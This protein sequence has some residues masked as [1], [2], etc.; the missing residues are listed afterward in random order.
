VSLRDCSTETEL[1]LLSLH[2][3]AC[4]EGIE[5]TSA[6]GRSQIDGVYD[7]VGSIISNTKQ[8][9]ENAF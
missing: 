6:Y 8:A 5:K 2:E 4:R 7:K 3:S 1:A 9:L